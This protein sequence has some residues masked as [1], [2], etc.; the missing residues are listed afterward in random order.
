MNPEVKITSARQPAAAQPPQAQQDNYRPARSSGKLMQSSPDAIAGYRQETSNLEAYNTPSGVLNGL[1]G[2]FIASSSQIAPS[3]PLVFSSEK[4]YSQAPASAS[5]EGNVASYPS[6][7]LGNPQGKFADSQNI[8]NVQNVNSPSGSLRAASTPPSGGLKGSATGSGSLRTASTASSSGGL[9]GSA[10]GSPESAA[11][12]NNPLAELAKYYSELRN[13]AH[14]ARRDINEL[15]DKVSRFDSAAKSPKMNSLGEIPQKSELQANLD[16]LLGLLM[17][18]NGSTLHLKTGCPPSVRIEGE[19]IPVGDQALTS[20]DTKRLI[21]PILNELHKESLVAGKDT[22]LSYTGAAGVFYVNAYLQRGQVSAVF[23]AIKTSVVPLAQLGLPDSLNQAL[24]LTSGLFIISGLSKSGRTT[25][26]GAMIDYLNN[27]TKS[28]IITVED[29]IEFLFK[30]NNSII[31]QR[32]A[33]VDTESIAEGVKS[34]IKQEPDILFISDISDK[35]AMYYALKAAETGY[36]V[37]AVMNTANVIQTLDRIINTFPEELRAWARAIL[38][39]TLC[40]ILAQKLIF[41]ETA[42]VRLPACE[43]MY[44]T[45]EIASLIR[46]GN[47]YEIYSR[48]KEGAAEGMITLNQSLMAMLAQNLITSDAVMSYSENPSELS[49]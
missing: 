15:K 6:G 21:L 11:F 17:Q 22:S 2:Q 43:L 48:I 23:K 25:T 47:H 30:D 7:M 37:I 20:N 42:Q 8:Q 4:N 28:N 9:K 5:S 32:E 19:L 13:E 14:R 12:R 1:P 29:P 40:G 49:E 26:A 36:L 31:S 41:S 24:S 3:A 27:N 39:D 38:A 46:I 44:V 34:A 18:H 16:D 33:G 45:P 10:T 35:D